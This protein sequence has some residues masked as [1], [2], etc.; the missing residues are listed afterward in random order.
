MWITEKISIHAEKDIS[1]ITDRLS[2][3]ATISNVILGWE[4]DHIKM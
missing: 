1:P 4:I 2:L 3:S